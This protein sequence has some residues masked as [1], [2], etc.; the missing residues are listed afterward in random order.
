[1][2]QVIVLSAN[3]EKRVLKS[4]AITGVPTGDMIAKAL[5]KKSA[6]EKIGAWE[7]EESD[8][9][10]LWGW[11][12]GKAGTENKHEL[13]PPHDKVLLFGDAIVTLHEDEDGEALN[14]KLDQWETF[15]DAAFEGFEDLGSEDSASEAEEES[16]GAESDSEFDDGDG[17]DDG[18]ASGD[19][20]G[21]EDVEEE[22][23]GSEAEEEEEEEEEDADDDCYDD[24][25]GGGG[26]RRA[27]RRRTVAAPEYRRIDM[28]LRSR[29]KMPT[30]PTKRAP[31][32]Q[33]AAE[34]EVEEY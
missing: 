19:D 25:D 26:K 10:V 34:L 2:V 15:Y 1:M 18:S 31:R 28:G 23:S 6:A 32:W 33:T 12:D 30:P 22:A 3:G 8:M 11:R 29:I 13:P 24:E 9:F 16:D 7:G 20:T 21:D 27:P 5:R 14:V 4:T 17:D